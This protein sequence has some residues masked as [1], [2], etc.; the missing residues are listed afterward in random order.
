[1]KLR[2]FAV[3]G[4]TAIILCL[5]INIFAQA[6]INGALKGRVI[7]QNAAGIGAATVV[8]VSTDSGRKL[9]Q[10]TDEAGNFTF[11]VLQPGS[12][13]LAAE[14]SGYKRLI[15]ENVIVTVGETAT[16]NFELTVGEVS[17][18]VTIE[19]GAE[20]VQ[21]QGAE[22]SQLVS[23]NR[24][25]NLPLNGKNFQQLV[26]LAPGVGGVISASGGITNPAISGARPVTNSYS[27]DGVAANDERTTS[28]LSIAG[29]AAGLSGGANIAPNL[30]STEAL[31]EF[32]IVTSN[33]DATYGRGSGGAIN[34]V[35]KSGANR[36]SGSLYEYLR[37][38]ALDARNFSIADRFSIPPDARK[39]RLSN[40]TCSA[41]RLAAE[42][43][44]TNISFSVHTKVFAK[45]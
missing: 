45:N 8:L 25:E 15:R 26:N 35:T 29:G 32:R 44:K 20:V 19:S 42:S 12:Y 7:D 43:S 23:G 28:G 1:M 40:K 10:T 17:E 14:K 24:I 3:A 31:K 27:I 22:I 13:S 38:D 5:S 39:M 18:T 16:A 41:E 30:V 2:G 6:N 4:C 34:V 11:S 21:S 33:S 36:F 37:N 9:S